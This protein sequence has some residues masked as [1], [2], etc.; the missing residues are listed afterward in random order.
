MNF[1][2]SKLNTDKA[3]EFTC[4]YI[5][6]PLKQF[7]GFNSAN[8]ELEIMKLINTGEIYFNNRTVRTSIKDALYDILS[9]SVAVV[10][11]K[12]KVAITFDNRG[13]QTRSI[14]EPTNENVIKGSKDCFVETLRFNT[15]TIHRKIKSVNCKMIR[16]VLGNETNTPVDIV[17]M[18]GIANMQTVNAIKDK[19]EKIKVDNCITTS[20]IEENLIDNKNSLFPQVIYT[21]RPDKFC[22]DIIEGYVGLLVDGIPFAYILPGTLLQCLQAP[23][24]YSGNFILNSLIRFMRF[25]LLIL[26]LFLPAFYTAILTFHQEMIPS[27]L[28]LSI[29]A[30]KE[31]VPFP[32]FIEVLLMLIAFEILI[33]SGIRLPKTIGSAV[34]IVGGIIVGQAAVQAELVSPAVVIVVSVTAISSFAIP[35][36]DF[37]NALRVWRLILVFAAAMLGLAGLFMF[38][39]VILADLADIEVFNIPFLAPFVSREQ[40]LSRDGIFRWFIPTNKLRSKHLNDVKD[41]RS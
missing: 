14:S 37:S 17:Y 32:T 39:L 2:K 7:D 30:S 12:E 4:D 19:L 34:S 41:K 22:A 8:S 10:F 33:E 3:I 29:K 11:D 40:G 23:E 27:E 36:Y 25:C 5:L 31:G 18:D 1:L 24:D 6:K 15:A 35:N 26:T 38:S 21:E 13:F 20:F 16:L 9:G 28:A